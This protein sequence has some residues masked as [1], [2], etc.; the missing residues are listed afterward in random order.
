MKAFR[1][2]AK[3]V[4]ERTWTCCDEAHQRS[5]GHKQMVKKL[6]RRSRRALDKAVVA[7]SVLVN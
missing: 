1:T 5:C 2:M 4:S 7:E 3:R 6:M